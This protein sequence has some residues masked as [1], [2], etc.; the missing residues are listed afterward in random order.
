[1]IAESRS[2]VNRPD[3]SIRGRYFAC[4]EELPKVRTMFEATSRDAV[5]KIVQFSGWKQKTK[6]AY[7]TDLSVR[8]LDIQL[9]SM[10]YHYIS[11]PQVQRQQLERRNI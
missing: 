2:N 4:C 7:K 5:R 11:I 9:C 1:M 10:K 3:G 8:L 6:R